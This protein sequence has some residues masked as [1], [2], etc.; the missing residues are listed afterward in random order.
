MCVCVCLCVCVIFVPKYIQQICR[1]LSVAS[2]LCSEQSQHYS[3]KFN[4]IKINNCMWKK[5]IDYMMK[6]L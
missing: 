4:I 1:V 2:Y 6:T 5:L 3:F